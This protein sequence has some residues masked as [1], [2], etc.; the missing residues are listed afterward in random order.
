[1]AHMAPSTYHLDHAQ[2]YT[3]Y[4]MVVFGNGN[5]L[6]ISHIETTHISPNIPLKNILLVPH[7]SR[8]L[9]SISQLTNDYLI[10][11]L[12]SRNLFNL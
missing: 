5:V 3:Y 1:M 4:H 11:V 8:K 2:P 6:H 9:L 12:F 10:D 7:L